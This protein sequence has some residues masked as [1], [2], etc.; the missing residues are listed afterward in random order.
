MIAFITE[1]LAGLASLLALIIW[2]RVYGLQQAE[3]PGN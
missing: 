1:P 3:R 2:G